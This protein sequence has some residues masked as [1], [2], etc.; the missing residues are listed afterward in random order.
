MIIGEAARRRHSQ[1][2]YLM[3]PSLTASMKA[4]IAAGAQVSTGPSQQR[5]S[6]SAIAPPGNLATSTQFPFGLLCRLLRHASGCG[7]EA[8]TPSTP[9]IDFTPS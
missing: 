3:R 1:A 7:S 5:E 4:L 2:G 9:V 6:R 8:G